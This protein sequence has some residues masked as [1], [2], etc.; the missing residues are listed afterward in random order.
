M[1]K[2]WLIAI[3]A[4]AALVIVPVW[5]AYAADE[6]AAPGAGQG[7]SMRRPQITLTD[8]QA[9]AMADQTAALKKAITDFQA[10]ATEVLDKDEAKGKAYTAQTIMQ[11][12]RDLQLMGGRRGGGGAGA[13]AG[14]GGQ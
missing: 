8:A 7:K 9:K 11:T 1:N 12:M 14:G 2:V 5:M 3:V 13:G 4:I 6:G 10:K